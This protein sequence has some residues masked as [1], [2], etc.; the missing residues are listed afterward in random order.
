MSVLARLLEN[1]VQ[2][3]LISIT[4]LSAKDLLKKL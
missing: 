4:N 3:V 2:C 1:L